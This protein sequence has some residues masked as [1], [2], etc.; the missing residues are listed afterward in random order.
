[1]QD[2]KIFKLGALVL[3]TTGTLLGDYRVEKSKFLPSML[4]NVSQSVLAQN[5]PSKDASQ[6][7][8]EVN[9]AVV[10]IKT[11][12]A[13]GSGFIYSE[14]GLIFTNAH[15]VEDAPKVVTVVFADG[16][17]ASADVVGFA[18]GGLD[19][20]ALQV[21]Q[22]KKLP[23]VTLA[24][25][26]SV[27]VGE[28]VFAIGTPLDS[29]FQNSFTQGN[30]TK[31]DRDKFDHIQHDAAI[32][33]GNSGGPLLNDRGE[34]IGVNSEGIVQ[35]GKLNTGMN[36]A[37]PV[38]KLI[39]FITAVKQDN[40]SPVSTRPTGKS[41]TNFREITLNGQTISDSLSEENRASYYIFEGRAGQQVTI[42]MVS[43]EINSAL[44]LVKAQISP[45]GEIEPEYKV[46]ENDDFNPG[47]LNARIETT[48]KEDGF[49]VIIAQSPYNG[50]YGTYNLQALSN[51]TSSEF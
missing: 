9:P 5:S 40:I 4:E 49:Y 24:Q 13:I 31:I 45:K 1:M 16:S 6:I 15:V 26:N 11:G 47:S 14:D 18:K 48:L 7:F 38:D 12:S 23:T 44:V 20:A 17:Q 19:L 28:P 46:D 37:I 43:E 39:S 50:E 2:I 36:F 32:F 42:D 10:T 22:S 25:P 21:Y 35:T 33:G 27:R 3:L 29:Q 51:D 34:V 8:E 30:V 41:E